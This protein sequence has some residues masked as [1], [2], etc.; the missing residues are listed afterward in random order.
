MSKML[1]IGGGVSGLCAGIYARLNG[2]EAT[3]CE[4]SSCVGGNLTGWQRE[5]IYIDNCIHW[6]TGTNPNTETYKRWVEVGML[7]EGVEII[8]PDTLFSYS[9]GNKTLSLTSDIEQFRKDLLLLSPIDEKEINSFVN[10]IEDWSGIIGIGGKNHDEKYGAIKTAKAAPNIL[11][12]HRM[13]TGQLSEKFVH[14]VIKKFFVSLL[15]S[16]FSA[17]VLIMIFAT[18]CYGNGG[19]PKGASL[20]AA[21]RM[22]NRFLS[23]GGEIIY[24]KEAVKVNDGEKT[25]VEFSDGVNMEADYVVLTTDPKVTFG[26]MLNVKMPKRLQALYDNPSMKRFSSVHCAFYSE[27]EL[28]FKGDYIIDVPEKYKNILGGSNIVL[29]EFSHD[30][31]LN[32]NKIMFESM[33][34]CGDERSR[35][36][37]DL[38]KDKSAYK[39]LKAEIAAS[40]EAIVVGKFPG[41]AG[42]I[43]PIDVWTPATYKRYVNSE[44]GS[45]MSFTIP[46]KYIP[47]KIDNKVEGYPHVILA[48]QWLLPPG[49]LPNAASVG[50]NAILTV[51]GM[52][53]R[54][55]TSGDTLKRRRYTIYNKAKYGKAK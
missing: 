47:R 37:I 34:F 31:S 35:Q 32:P 46:P 41:L 12:Y 19:V 18:F 49:G 36:F 21:K 28:C 6:L 2:L 10:A 17:F 20:E 1:I 48:N 44:I 52:E 42:K 8:Q 30:R 50:R 7:G 40:V 22:E 54:R 43:R 9:Y 53:Q 3:I 27:E 14:P 11:K 55:S 45:Y 23:L 39:S 5:G 13:S 33:I 29:R 24:N 4:R 26:E 16:E 15:G 51:L 25:V 38:Y